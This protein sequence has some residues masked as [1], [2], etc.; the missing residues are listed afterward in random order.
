MVLAPEALQ[1]IATLLGRGQQV[2]APLSRL[3]DPQGQYV[4]SPVV[5][6]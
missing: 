1:Q 2:L 5:A 4:L 6:P 3:D